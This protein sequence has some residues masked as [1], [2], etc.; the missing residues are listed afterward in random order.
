M[1]SEQR[2]EPEA[3]ATRLG[4]VVRYPAEQEL[5]IDIDSEEA[6]ATFLKLFEVFKE[7]TDEIAT[8]VYTPSPSGKPGHF[9]VVVT[10]SR[11]L[12]DQNERI[13]FQALL[14]SDTMRELI[15]Y[16][17]DARSCFFERPA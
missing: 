2:E 13:V 12:K 5:F 10:M 8:Y 16:T 9:H 14:G 15:A 6:F 3:K 7:H 1:S 11:P 4:L 17:H